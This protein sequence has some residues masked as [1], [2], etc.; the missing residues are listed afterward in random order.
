MMHDL[1]AEAGGDLL[2]Q[3]LDARRGEL[4]HLAGVEVDQVVVVLGRRFEAGGAAGK[5]VA[6]DRPDSSSAFIVR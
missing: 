4:D 1:V 5:G 3:R 2:L 6:L